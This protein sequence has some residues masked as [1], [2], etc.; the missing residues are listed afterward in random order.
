MAA[1]YVNCTTQG[2]WKHCGAGASSGSKRKGQ[3]KALCMGRGYLGCTLSIEASG[4]PRCKLLAG[5]AAAGAKTCRSG[6]RAGSRVGFAGAS[7]S[8]AASI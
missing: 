3:H 4:E 2:D 5:Y 7:A 1:F 8:A 6:E